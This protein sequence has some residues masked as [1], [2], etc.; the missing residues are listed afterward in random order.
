MS[1]NYYHPNEHEISLARVLFALSDPIRLNMVRSLAKHQRLN[2]SDLG[3]NMPKS[4]ITHHT[5]ILRESGVTNTNTEGRY[6][7]ISL[8]YDMLN[9]KFPGL[10]NSILQ[11]QEEEDV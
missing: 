6:C 5:R 8:R 11:V 4:T 3:S 9:K 2:S 7:W 1:R 10:L